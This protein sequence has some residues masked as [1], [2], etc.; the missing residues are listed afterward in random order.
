[1]QFVKKFF[2]FLIT[3][4]AFAVGV[5]YLLQATIHYSFGMPYRMFLYHLCFPLSYIFIPCFFYA[6]IA[7][8]L[9]SYFSKVSISYKITLTIIICILVTLISS[10]FG[11]MLWHYHDMQAGYFPDNWLYKMVSLGFSWG[12]RDGWIIVLMSVPY[13]IIG[14]VICF[15]LTNYLSKKL[16]N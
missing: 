7:T 10:P 12:L 6:L 16:E 13:N 14:T 2:I 3:S 5:H 11:G 1:M 15:F 9:S 4:Y 8:Y